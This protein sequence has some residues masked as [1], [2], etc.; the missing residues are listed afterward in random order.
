MVLLLVSNMTESKQASVLSPLKLV[1]FTTEKVVEINGE[2]DWN[3]L[4]KARQ[5]ETEPQSVSL[6]R[7]DVNPSKKIAK[8]Q[9]DVKRSSK[10][11]KNHIYHVNVYT[12]DVNEWVACD[13][14]DF[15]GRHRACKHSLKCVLIGRDFLT[16]IKE[17]IISVAR[18]LSPFV[19]F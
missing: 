19:S 8:I 10:H 14:M 2:T 11:K 15:V 5:N 9:F 13:C 1:A 16:K 6:V 3:V 7:F 12:N 17:S 18:F 4:W